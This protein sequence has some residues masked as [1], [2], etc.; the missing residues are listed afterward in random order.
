MSNFSKPAE[1]LSREAKDYIDLRLEDVK[2]RTARGLSVA[3]SKLVGYILILSVATSLILALS[4][5]LIMLIGELIGSYAWASLGVAVLIGV[6][7]WIL[8][9]KRDLLFKDTFVPLFL[10]LFFNDDDDD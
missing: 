4:F 2:L 1:D 3:A 10:N 8:I 7:L 9:R 6:G 5:G